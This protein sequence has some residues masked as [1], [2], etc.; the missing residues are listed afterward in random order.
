[1]NIQAYTHLT[2][3]SITVVIIVTN[4]QFDC[5]KRLWLDGLW[6]VKCAI[7]RAS[8]QYGRVT[9]KQTKI[10]NQ[11]HA[12]TTQ[13]IMHDNNIYSINQSLLLTNLE[14]AGPSCSGA[15]T[16]QSAIAP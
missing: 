12:L 4:L 9:C 7:D 6:M 1:M 2:S 16:I 3:V 5:A 11:R 13:P 14:T 8:G 15:A 10:R